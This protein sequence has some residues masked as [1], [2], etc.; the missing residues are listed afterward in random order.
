MDDIKA[1][2]ARI[3]AALDR[4]RY[5]LTVDHGGAS[6]ADVTA[7]LQDERD[8]NAQLEERVRVLKSRQDG[9]IAELEGRVA[10]QAAQLAALDAELQKLRAS[11][12]D[13]TEV[14]GKL[15]AA[16]TAG[17]ADAELINRALM[18]EVDGLTAQR[19]AEAAEVAAILA[20]L[21]PLLK[22]EA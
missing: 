20:D 9:R 5:G 12:A 4:I 3:T 6:V 2:E 1:Y 10:E 8:A 14:S 11:N 13:L 7:Q 19:S 18:A 21:K 17:T 22:E 16:A 15:R